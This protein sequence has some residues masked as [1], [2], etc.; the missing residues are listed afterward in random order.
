MRQEV[1]TCR[2][3]SF[4]IAILSIASI[5][6]APTAAVSQGSPEDPPA[7]DACPD[8]SSELGCGCGN[9]A[10]DPDC[11]CGRSPNACGSCV[12]DLSCL[13]TPAPVTCD[14]TV[15]T[16]G[17]GNYSIY[18]NPR[19]KGQKRKIYINRIQVTIKKGG[20]VVVDTSVAIDPCNR[21]YNSLWSCAA[22]EG[23][24]NPAVTYRDGQI[25]WTDEEG[26][27]HPLLRE[28]INGRR[29][30][31]RSLISHIYGVWG[32]PSTFRA[33]LKEASSDFCTI[34][35]SRPQ[36]SPIVL[37]MQGDG[38]RFTN[39]SD[40]FIRFDFGQKGVI[41]SWVA[42]P[43]AVAF[44]AVDANQNGQIDSI[45][46]MF[47]DK[48]TI[49]GAGPF[50]DGFEAL[51][52]FD[53]NKDGVISAADAIFSKL[54]LW[55]DRN[56]NGISEPNEL[57]KAAVRIEALSTKSDREKYFSDAQNSFA[58]GR[59]SVKL[60]GGE[61]R[62]SYD[63]WFAEGPNELFL[64]GLGGKAEPLPKQGEQ[65]YNAV[66]D[67]L[68]A[69]LQ[70]DGF[71]PHEAP[72]S[73]GSVSGTEHAGKQFKVVRWPIGPSREC[74]GQLIFDSEWQLKD[75]LVFCE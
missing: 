26:V 56:R 75:K 2:R 23:S 53:D 36:V 70:E 61:S 47:G 45:D 14:L 55:H 17:P 59:A 63:A 67:G 29:Q 71:A 22:T 52:S 24:S 46:E 49:K 65:H 7:A 37:D 12:G 4:A 43:D 74:T 5:C 48:T 40:E 20:A 64:P 27:K 50:S 18:G 35:S 41:T 25:T 13:P 9:P 21:N 38:L 33:T 6:F 54:V 66:A 19:D 44:L 68:Q 62:Y 73:T 30:S 39:P 60:K 28:S 8:G 11:G 32:S 3:L 58:F 16:R 57:E 42:N 69:L 10:P 34:D 72:Y 15:S 1:V 31:E 51:A